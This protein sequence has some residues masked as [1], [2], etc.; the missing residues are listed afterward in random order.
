MSMMMMMMMM[1]MTGALGAAGNKTTEISRLIEEEKLKNPMPHKFSAKL[2]DGKTVIL[3]TSSG[4]QHTGGE[5]GAAL[6]MAHAVLE[7]NDA[8]AAADDDD[9]DRCRRGRAAFD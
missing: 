2:S 7:G 5:D 4:T 8:A 1:M 3:D 9:D 6:L